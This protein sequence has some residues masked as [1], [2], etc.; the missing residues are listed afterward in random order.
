MSSRLH[1]ENLCHNE[2]WMLCVHSRQ[3][4]KHHHGPSRYVQ[5]DAMSNLMMSLSQWLSSYFRS[6]PS[7][8]KKL[9]VILAMTIG[10]GTLLGC[11]LYCCCTMYVG[12][13]DS[14]SEAPDTLFNNVTTNLPKSQDMWIFFN[15]TWIS[16]IPQPPRNAPCQREVIR[17]SQH[18]NSRLRNG[19]LSV[20]IL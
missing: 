4:R 11:G 14:P 10:T 6:V 3:F 16:S 1:K 7:W 20:G 2:N 9:L 15:C 8:W 17:L 5:T 12:L 19:T 18:P 13:Q